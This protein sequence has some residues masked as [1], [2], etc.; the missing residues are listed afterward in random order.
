MLGDSRVK[1]KDIVNE[2]LW[3]SAKEFGKGVISALPSQQMQ[4]VLRSIKKAPGGAAMTDLEAAQAAYDKFGDAPPR[5]KDSPYAQA[6]GAAAWLTDDQLRALAAAKN[7][8]PTKKSAKKTSQT[9]RPAATQN[10]SPANMPSASAANIPQGHRIV[11][12]NP[13]GN[14]TFYKYPDGRWT[15]EFGN[16]MPSG[17]HGALE[18][19]ADTAGRMEQTPTKSVSGFKPR[20]ARRAQ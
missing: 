18:Q 15:D 19:F 14:A 5:P 6:S 12:R 10:V 13:Q 16:A 7:K 3:Q 11:V 4:D 1:I 20:G 8:Q 2:G 9:N 17:A